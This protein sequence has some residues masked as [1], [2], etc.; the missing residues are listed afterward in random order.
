V[1]ATKYPNLVKDRAYHPLEDTLSR[2]LR[3]FSGL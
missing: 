1:L 3:E 2:I